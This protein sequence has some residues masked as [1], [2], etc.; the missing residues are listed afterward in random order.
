MDRLG[1]AFFRNVPEDPGVY[2]L[3]DATDVVLYVGKARNLR[4]RL[5]SY[6][7]ANPE[8]L[9]RRRVRLLHLA[10]RIEWQITTDEAAALARERVLLRELKPRFNRAGVWPG[11]PRQLAWRVSGKGLE[12]ALNAPESRHWNQHGPLG[13]SASRLRTICVRLLWCGWFPERALDALPAGWIQGH[14]PPVVRLSPGPGGPDVLTVAPWFSALL[15]G[16]TTAMRAWL[17]TGALQTGS[18]FLRALLD[19]DLAW[20]AD[21]KPPSETGR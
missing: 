3:R 10:R 17:E 15:E 8:L 16:E 20:I 2:L 6:R 12:L 9:P 19:A 7:V 4:R 1:A 11:Q 5:H 14:F 18:P 13:A 21:R